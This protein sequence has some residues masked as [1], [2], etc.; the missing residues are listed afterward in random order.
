M[1]KRA[2]K[3]AQHQFIHAKPYMPFDALIV[4][5][6]PFE[7]G[8]WDRVMKARVMWSWILYKNGFVKNIIYSGAAVYSPYY[9]AVIMGL[10]AQQ[11]G[12][13][14]EHIFYDTIARHS[15]ENVFYSYLIARKNGFKTLAL[16]TDPYFQSPLLKSFTKRRFATYIHHVPFII[17]SL[18]KYDNLEPQINPATAK[19]KTFN[20]IMNE[21][22]FRKRFRGTIGKDIDWK[23]FKDGRLDPL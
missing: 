20:S 23:Q 19:V 8:K 6:V 21:E 17:D 15:T 2:D 1:S 16:G 12:I 13:P 14:K 9:E 18:K 22:N 4:P 11:L 10:Y 3:S 5:G 7:N